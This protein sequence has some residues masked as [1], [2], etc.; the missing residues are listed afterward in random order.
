MDC[1]R[2]VLGV[3]VKVAVPPAASVNSDLFSVKLPQSIPPRATE[4][5]ICL[6]LTLV[7]VKVWLSKSEPISTVQLVDTGVRNRFLQVIV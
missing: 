4:T 5:I 2:P 1:L 6:L 7:M 3:T